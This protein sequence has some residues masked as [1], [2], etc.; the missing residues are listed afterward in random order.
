[1]G[2]YS[3]KEESAAVI[4][5]EFSNKFT[6]VQTDVK[7]PAP[8]RIHNLQI[9]ENGSTV[10]CSVTNVDDTGSQVITIYVEGKQI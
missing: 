9:S 5:L 3:K 2:T 6:Y 10:Q 1:M 8:L 7:N 4:A